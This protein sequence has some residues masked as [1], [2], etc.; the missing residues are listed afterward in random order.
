MR[1][2]KGV[3]I[4]ISTNQYP[5]FDLLNIQLL[6]CQEVGDDIETDSQNAISNDSEKEKDI[7]GID[8]FYEEEKWYHHQRKYN[9]QTLGEGKVDSDTES[10]P[11]GLCEL[12]DHNRNIHTQN[13]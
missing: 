2:E 8:T 13:R 1:N 7:D 11:V 5:L 4:C 12:S 3:L 9:R 6:C 10:N